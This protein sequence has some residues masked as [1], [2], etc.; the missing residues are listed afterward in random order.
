MACK[1]FIGVHG[2]SGCGAG[3]VVMEHGLSALW[4]ECH[5]WGTGA[6]LGARLGRQDPE[7]LGKECPGAQSCG[8]RGARNLELGME[9]VL[10]T[11]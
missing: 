3:S 6:A 7:L 4:R 10:G 8:R 11:S 1:I 2:L 9:K 5:C